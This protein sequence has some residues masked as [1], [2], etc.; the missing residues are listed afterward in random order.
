MPDEGEI[1][2]AILAEIAGH[3]IK[4]LA[5]GRYT[6]KFD[7]ASF[8]GGDGLDVPAAIKRI[9]VPTLLIRAE[10][11][12]IMTA[13]ASANAI[14]SNPLVRLIEIPGAHHHVPLES[15]EPLARAIVEFA[16][17]VH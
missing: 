7:R 3:S 6:M 12:R 4:R 10:L 11:S 16:A 5:D 15:P 17:T 14:A 9:S 1:S 2:P 13:E 8:F